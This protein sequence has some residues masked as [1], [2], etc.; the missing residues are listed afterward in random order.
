MFHF[1]DFFKVGISESGNHDN[2]VYEDDWGERYEGLLEKNGG[3]DNYAA[4]A[5]ET[6]AKTLKGK[7][8][9]AH[10]TLDDNVP[11]ANTTW[12]SIGVSVAGSK[13]AGS[14]IPGRLLRPAALPGCPARSTSCCGCSRWC[15]WPSRGSPRTTSSS[16]RRRT[17]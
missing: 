4:E 11:S 3:T 2:R 7:L 15:R 16:P 17:R 1:P 12:V 13:V 8:L 14:G 6:Y 5:N 10:G 9:L